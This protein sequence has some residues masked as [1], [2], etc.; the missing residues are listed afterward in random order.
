MQPTENELPTHEQAFEWPQSAIKENNWSEA[1]KRWAVIR[2]AYPNHP[3]GWIQGA[4]S[5]LEA[6]ELDRAEKLITHCH[7]SFP[8]HPNTLVLL[9]TLAMKRGEIDKSEDYLKRAR[10]RHS[11]HLP[12]WLTS[13]KNAEVKGDIAQAEAYYEKACLCSPDRAAPFIGYAELAM[14]TKQWETALK[15]WQLVR[16]KFPNIP[17][18]FHRAAEAARQ[19]GHNKEARQ[20]VLAQQYGT[21]ILSTDHEQQNSTDGKSKHSSLLLFVELIFTKA[22]LNLRSEVHRNYLSYG[23]WILEPLLYMGVFYV[24]FGVLLNRGDEN[25]TTFLMTGLIPWMWFMKTVSACSSSILAGQNLMLQVGLPSIVFPLISFTQSTIKQIPVFILLIGFVL[26]Q[27]YSP[28]NAWW[29]LIL[30]FLVQALL[31][32]L[33]ACLVAAI[34]P[35]VRDLTYLVPTG[36]TFLMFL[37]GI[38]YDYRMISVEW[39]DMFLL[40]PIA[41]ILKSYREVFIESTMPELQVLFWWGLGSGLGFILLLIVYQRLRYIYPRIV[42][43]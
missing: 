41:F 19:L 42:L 43:E 22:K 32:I 38:F 21:D 2:K 5:L 8:N 40:N 27:G 12:V 33:I 30:L 3:A 36:L 11:D 1:A 6:S 25:Y 29:S 28:S 17:T 14:R 39:Q 16:D 18:G 24:V 23:W 37:S 26:L 20:L 4:N 13:A 7:Q 15:R 34:I 9:A 31:T 35:F 10:D